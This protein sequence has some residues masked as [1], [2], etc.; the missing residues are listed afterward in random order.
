VSQSK[1]MS[2]YEALTN[3]VL[4]VVIGFCIVYF[5]LPFI[6]VCVS[7]EQALSTNA[8]FV[9]ASTARGYVVRRGFVWLGEVWGK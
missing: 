9:V 5:V 6:G 1:R 8:M 7:V 4:G 2:F 3:T